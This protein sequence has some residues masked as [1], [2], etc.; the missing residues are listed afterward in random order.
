MKRKVL[1]FCISLLC[2]IAFILI[3]GL[4]ASDRPGRA[5]N[6]QVNIGLSERFT[7]EEIES[8]AG[9]VIAGFGLPNSELTHLWYDEDVSNFEIERSHLALDKESTVVLFSTIVVRRIGPGWMYP[10]TH[11][12]MGWVLARDSQ[13]GEWEIIAFG[14][15]VLHF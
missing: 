14:F 13:A 1:T 9:I 10:G 7:P 5:N 15:S 11:E 2:A 6:V 12:N 8:A 4:I 3:L